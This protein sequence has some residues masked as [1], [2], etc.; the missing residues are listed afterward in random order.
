MVRNSIYTGSNLPQLQNFIKRDPASYKDDFLQQYT[1]FL[2]TLEVFQLA[3]GDMNKNLDD[4]VMFIAQTIQCYPE[5]MKQFPQ[6][7]MDILKN[8]S[9]IMDPQMRKGFC[10]ALAMMR[11]KNI[12]CP[13]EL[14]RCYFQL[15]KCQDK[16]LRSFLENYI[17]TDIKNIYQKQ[18][19]AKINLVSSKSLLTTIT[20]SN[21]I[22]VLCR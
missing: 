8:Q 17:I 19:G 12:L 1:H 9:T 10:K 11:F 15:L 14:F 22:Y 18:K 16:E 13:L 20:F 7:L 6:L 2:S 4:L 3:P 5:E 21:K